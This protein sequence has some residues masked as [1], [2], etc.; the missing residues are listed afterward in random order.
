MYN[1]RRNIW[2]RQNTR[3]DDKSVAHSVFYYN[4]FCILANISFCMPKFITEDEDRTALLTLLFKLWVYFNYH[5]FFSRNQ[6]NYIRKITQFLHAFSTHMWTV[7]L[8]VLLLY[9][10]TGWASGDG[11]RERRP[12]HFFFSVVTNAHIIIVRTR[13]AE[14]YF[15]WV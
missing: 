1:N 14:I 13:S 3:N 10:I 6:Q 7:L 5:N 15:F 11:E 9:L 8:L 2:A 4:D 12:V